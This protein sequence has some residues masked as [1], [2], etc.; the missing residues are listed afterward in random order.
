MDDLPRGPEA[1]SGT[2]GSLMTLEAVSCPRG[3]LYARGI[4]RGQETAS[5]TI[6]SLEGKRQSQAP[7]GMSTEVR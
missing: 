1:L 4:P 6:D 2:R 3:C 5:R 7:E